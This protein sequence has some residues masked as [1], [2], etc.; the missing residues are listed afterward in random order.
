MDGPR[1]VNHQTRRSI[2]RWDPLT[3]LRLRRLLRRFGAAVLH[4]GKV[5]VDLS[6]LSPIKVWSASYVYVQAC[7]P[8][9][10]TE[11]G[12]NIR[13]RRQGS[14]PMDVMLRP[15]EEADIPD[16]ARLF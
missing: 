4:N 5:R 13:I 8:I 12:S 16:L 14:V 1:R 2:K 15:A 9:G 3:P 11:T 7:A 6:A 10:P